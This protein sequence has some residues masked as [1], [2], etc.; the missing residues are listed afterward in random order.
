MSFST[1]NPLKK[2]DKTK[3]SVPGKVSW[4][5]KKESADAEA[6]TPKRVTAAIEKRIVLMLF[7]KKLRERRYRG[8][9]IRKRKGDSKNELEEEAFVCTSFYIRRV[10]GFAIYMWKFYWLCVE[11]ARPSAA[12]T[13][14]EQC[15]NAPCYK[16]I[17]EG[18]KSRQRTGQKWSWPGVKFGSRQSGCST[19]TSKPLELYLFPRVIPPK[20]NDL[21]DFSSSTTTSWRYGTFNKFNITSYDWH[22][23]IL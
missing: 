2:C 15:L 6:A 12:Q 19:K 1:K 23:S 13:G 5:R 7:N 8:Q 16:D 14:P 4:R 22:I 18:I 11:M 9:V 3:K 17:R 10:W 21:L 20:P